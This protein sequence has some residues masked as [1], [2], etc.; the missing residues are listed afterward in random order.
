MGATRPHAAHTEGDKCPG[1]GAPWEEWPV[2]HKG[3]VVCSQ[4]CEKAANIA[5]TPENAAGTVW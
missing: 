4:R 5:P 2:A 3:D 1:C